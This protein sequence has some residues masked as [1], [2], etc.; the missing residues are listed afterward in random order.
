M[1][2]VIDCNGR[3]WRR[4][5][6]F[7]VALFFAMALAT[8]IVYRGLPNKVDDPFVLVHEPIHMGTGNGMH[9]LPDPLEKMHAPVESRQ[10]LRFGMA[11]AG[12]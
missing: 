9:A 7:S 12:Q 3:L 1:V 8:A 11:M 4:F 6:L 2:G 5:Q 10:Q